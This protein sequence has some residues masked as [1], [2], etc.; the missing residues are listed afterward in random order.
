M[1]SAQIAMTAVE[2]ASEEHTRA[3]SLT[4]QAGKVAL[5]AL[6]AVSVFSEHTTQAAAFE[7]D[8]TTNLQSAQNHH[9]SSRQRSTL[10]SMEISWRVE[11]LRAFDGPINEF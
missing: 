9:A 8:S 11:Q 2:R 10:G 3:A 1:Q 5:L 7:A 6:A 4:E